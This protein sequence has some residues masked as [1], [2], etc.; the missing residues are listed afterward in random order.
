MKLTR[1]LTSFC[2]L[3][4]VTAS[5]VERAAIAQTPGEP[6]TFRAA[7]ELVTVD[8]VVLDNNGRAV[9][10]LTKDDFVLEEDGEPQQIVSFE[11]FRLDAEPE[12]E[13]ATLAAVASNESTASQVGRGFAI[14][15]DDVGL[16]AERSEVARKAVAGR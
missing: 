14:L 10:F 1:V 8:A 3:G 15:V 13:P 4:L 2:V 12:P 5:S 6:P 11:A 7:V 9:P 16:A